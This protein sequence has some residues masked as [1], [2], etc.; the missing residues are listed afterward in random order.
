ME[1]HNPTS[2]EGR[3]EDGGSGGY[4]LKGKAHSVSHLQEKGA[5]VPVHI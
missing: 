2:G 3:D 4:D 1:P 5:A